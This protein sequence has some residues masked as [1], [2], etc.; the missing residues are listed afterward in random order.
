MTYKSRLKGSA[1]AIESLELD[2]KCV[3]DSIE[4]HSEKITIGTDIEYHTEQIEIARAK[5][6]LLQHA[7]ECIQ[8]IDL[9]RFH[10]FEERDVN[11]P[12]LYEVVDID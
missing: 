9:R 2:I 12:I 1:Q 3:R 7:L 6:Q 5:M 8:E 4:Y 10:E 11:E